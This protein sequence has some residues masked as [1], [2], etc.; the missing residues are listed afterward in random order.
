MQTFISQVVKSIIETDNNI[1]NQIIILPSRRAGVFF[2]DEL[3]RQIKYSTWGPKILTIED[4]V[5][6]ISSLKTID[7]IHLLFSFYE[8]YLQNSVDHEYDTFDQFSK[9]A[10]MALYDFNEI[11]RYLVDSEKLFSNLRDIKK[12]ES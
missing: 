7:N 3:L 10:T 8:V 9:W 1:E 12:I 2:K 11:D 5:S 4:L 6:E